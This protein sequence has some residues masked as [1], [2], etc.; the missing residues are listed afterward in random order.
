MNLLYILDIRF[1]IF[2]HQNVV[3]IYFKLM[4][5]RNCLSLGDLYSLIKLFIKKLIIIL[6]NF[7]D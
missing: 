3:G 7:M 6:L 5:V 1:T 2:Y 4:K